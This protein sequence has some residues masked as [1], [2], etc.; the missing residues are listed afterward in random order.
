VAFGKPGRP[1]EDRLARQAEIFAA[2]ARLRVQVGPGRR[3][4]RAAGRAAHRSVGGLS[5][6]F[7]TKPELV[8]H[9]LGPEPLA[10]RCDG[11]TRARHLAGSDPAAY[12]DACVEHTVRLMW[13]VRP[14]MAAAWSW[15]ATPSVPTVEGAVASG[16]ADVQAAAAAWS[17]GADVE[18]LGRAIRH[19]PLAVLV[20]RGVTRDQLAGELRA[21]VGR[22][23]RR[24]RP[25]RGRPTCGPFDRSPAGR[26]RRRSGRGRR[27]DALRGGAVAELVLL[28]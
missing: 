17:A 10:R 18:R 26:S 4:M 8:L 2:V 11:P 12:L 13:F 6:W 25:G 23:Q 19:L 7:P 21:L 28:A 3:S 16:I 5:H 9:A 20:D 22:H 27:S 14:A 1:A 24:R 15:A